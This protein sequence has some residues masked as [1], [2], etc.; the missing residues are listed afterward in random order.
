MAFETERE[1]FYIPGG[2]RIMVPAGWDVV[3]CKY[4]G[5]RIGGGIILGSERAGYLLFRKSVTRDKKDGGVTS[6]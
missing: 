6:I 4:C 2:E 5:G 3:V 1:T